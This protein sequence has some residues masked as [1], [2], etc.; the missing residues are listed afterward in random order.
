MPHKTSGTLNDKL[1]MLI[2]L[3]GSSCGGGL[4][5]YLNRYLRKVGRKVHVAERYM[6][7]KGTCG[8]KV[9]VAEWYMWQK[10]RQTG[11]QKGMW[12]YQGLESYGSINI[13]SDLKPTF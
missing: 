1:V 10:G 2:K 11:R 4:L 6:W 5:V 13:P 8:R 7:Q 3:C 9:H 12:V